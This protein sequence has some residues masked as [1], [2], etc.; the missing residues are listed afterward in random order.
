MKTYQLH[1]H[2]I[3]ILSQFPALGKKLAA[4]SGNSER[5]ISLGGDLEKSG[6]FICAAIGLQTPLALRVLTREECVGLV[7][8]LRTRNFIVHF[9]LEACGFGWELQRELRAAG[10]QVLTFAPEP[11]TGK[12]KTNRRDAGAIARL[13]A[14]RVIHGDEK[15]GRVVR[16][17][18]QLEQERRALCRHRQQLVGIRGKLEA[19]GRNLLHDFGIHDAPECWWGKKMWPVLRALLSGHGERGQW[20]LSLLEPQ[21]ELARATHQRIRALD[22]QLA[23]IGREVLKVPIPKGLG[24]ATATLVALEMVDPGRFKN[25]KQVGSYLGCSPREHSTGDGQSLGRI[26]KIGNKRIRSALTEAVWRLIRWE[27]GW[28]GFAK[29]GDILRDKKAGGIRKKKALI[30]C[31][32]LLGIDLWRL[33]TGRAT[34]ELLGFTAQKTPALPEAA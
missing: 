21:R 13:V 27:P 32:R 8:E 7:K 9:G 1:S 6:L 20:L 5:V 17:P 24:E 10:A 2:P 11:L 25:R 16:E 22:E 3:S 4:A 29:W 28:R 31:V 18:T 19:F 12:R 26:D 33:M 14:A 15:A 34:L 30:A 23:Q